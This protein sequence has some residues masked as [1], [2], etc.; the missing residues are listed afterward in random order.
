MNK[1]VIEFEMPQADRIL[2][3]IKRL[4]ERLD[5]VEMT[6]RSEWITVKE[7]AESVGRTV[8]TI[9]NWIRDGSIETRRE[10][11]VRMVMRSA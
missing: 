9:N 6:P 7:Y 4:H 3:E 5:A 2:Q 11:R 10:G 1:Q 8:Q